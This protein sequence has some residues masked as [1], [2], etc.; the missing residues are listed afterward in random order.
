MLPDPG[1]TQVIVIDRRGAKAFSMLR[2]QGYQWGANLWHSTALKSQS[3]DQILR[4]FGGSDVVVFDEMVQR[5][6]DL[7][8]VR[9]RLE[10]VG[11]AVRSICLVRR[12]SLFLGGELVDLDVEPVEDLSD[13][14]FDQA[15]TFLSHLFDYCQPPLD[16]EHVL[17]VGKLDGSAS[18]SEIRDRLTEFGITQL[19]WNRQATEDSAVAAVTLD[20]PLFFDVASVELPEG[21]SAEWDGPCKVRGYISNA[22][23]HATLAFITFPT[24]TGEDDAWRALVERTRCRYQGTSSS[25]TELD[26]HTIART[27]IDVCTD[28]SISLLAQS[29]AAG[30]FDALGMTSTKGPKAS[31]LTAFF[32]AKRG[33]EMRA[34][35]RDALE[36]R[37]PSLAL[38]PNRAVP[39]VI[40][41]ARTLAQA[42]D[43]QTGQDIVVRRLSEAKR[44]RLPHSTK[45]G[46]TYGELLMATRP[47]EEAA[48]SAALDGL[49]DGVRAKPVALVTKQPGG[50]R[51]ARG[52]DASEYGPDDPYDARDVHRAQA[53]AVSAFEQWLGHRRTPDE[54]EIHVA[55]LFANLVHDW[56]KNFSRLA[57][58]NHPYKHGMMPRLETKVP[59]RSEEP[60]YLLR[61]LRRASLLSVRRDG[62]S[63]RYSVTAGLRVAD[64]VRR[65]GLNGHERAQVKSL[66]R[67]YALA[68]ENC[69]V[70]R[71]KTP[72]GA[73]PGTFG[74]PL[75]VLS[76]ARNEKIAY[77]C[78]LFEIGDWIA[79][80]RGLFR[81]LVGHGLQ[82]EPDPRFAAEVASET[83][84][85]AQAAAFLFG[86]LSMYE[87]VPE[88]RQQLAQLFE[89]KELDA[90]EIIL[91]SVARATRWE[92]DY[93][94]TDSP[95]GLLRWAHGVMRPFTSFVRQALTQFG[96]ESDRRTP[97]GRTEKRD[98][99]TVIEKDVRFYAAEFA[100]PVDDPAVTSEITRLAE[101]VLACAGD[102]S[103]EVVVLQQISAL[104]EQVIGILKHSI[105]TKDE[106]GEERARRDERHRDLIAVSRWYDENPRLTGVGSLVAV[107]DFYNFVNFVKRSATWTGTTGATIAEGLH[108][109]ILTAAKA[110]E[111]HFP[112]VVTRVSSDTCILASDDADELLSA[113]QRMNRAMCLEMEA[114]DR[115]V[116]YMRFGMTAVETDFFGPICDALH[117]GDRHG[118]TRGGVALDGGVF[119][120]L[121]LAN[122]RRTAKQP[123]LVRGRVFYV[124]A[125]T[126]TAA[127]A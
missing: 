79:I 111:E 72:G 125:N 19:I 15:A 104:F 26:E 60:R 10:R 70:S 2:P 49:L 126:T 63:D 8:D 108:D 93:S 23:R 71:R 14:D 73:V 57:I 78:A 81:T 114:L 5:G 77:D 82:G 36:S 99:G 4:Q 89:E 118:F 59:W 44:A 127:A 76:S 12:R 22:G 105:K 87:A 98:D 51:A 64:L 68:Q 83:E 113:V 117:L 20:R 85:F 18:A 122:K 16:P 109:S 53:V 101:R 24:L 110:I 43:P 45:S 40:D 42:V 96:L 103:Q 47:V 92:L 121:G 115:D 29:A 97:S 100:T 69:K 21:I 94:T 11:L 102:S 34:Q 38:A 6:R 88:L 37:Q 106:I 50:Y 9:H 66:V 3:D 90:G 116:A 33:R 32:G 39:L 124:I 80:G 13:P 52:F 27:Y 67:A 62:R 112:N 54:T 95:M 48:V 65:G 86:K 1:R 84:A 30:L 120:R 28:F 17:V 119:Q 91:E 31:E 61:E 25:A 74:D 35:I 58:K 41:R 56:G 55:K 46:L 123:E 107:G 7:A 75:V